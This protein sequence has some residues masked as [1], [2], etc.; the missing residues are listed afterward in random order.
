MSHTDAHSHDA[1]F[2]QRNA[3]LDDATTAYKAAR[4]NTHPAIEYGAGR[5]MTVVFD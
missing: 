2:P 5:N 3:I 4:A 1:V